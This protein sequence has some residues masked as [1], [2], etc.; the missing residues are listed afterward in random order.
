[1]PILHSSAEK[2][3]MTMTKEPRKY[4]SQVTADFESGGSVQL[5]D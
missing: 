5:S 3:I 4:A 1:M 2:R